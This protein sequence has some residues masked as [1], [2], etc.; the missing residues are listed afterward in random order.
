MKSLRLLL[1]M[2]L[3]FSASIV[4]A[5]TGECSGT[6][7]DAAEGTFDLGFDYTIV[8]NGEDVTVSVELLDIK[9]G[10]VAYAQTYNPDFAEVPMDN[11]GGQ[12]FSKTFPGQVD[13]NSFNVAIKFAF[14][15]GL[16]T[17]TIIE[18]TV[19]VG[20]VVVNT[21]ECSGTWTDA[22]EGTFD[23]GFDYSIITEGED[24]TVSVELL[25]IKDG[26]VAFA[27]TYTPDFAEVPMDNTGGQAFSKTFPGQVDGNSF[28]VAIKFAFAGGLTTSTIIEYTVGEGC[29]GGNTSDISL[30][31]TFEDEAIDYELNDFEGTTSQ[32]IIDPTDADNMV[33]ETVKSETA[34]FFAGTTVADVL[35]FSEPIP[36][37]AGATSMSVR[38]WSPTADTPVRL[39]VEQVG[40]PTVSVETEAMTT[41][42]EQWETL[43][44]NFTNQVDG[45]AAIN[46]ASIYNKATIFFNFGTTGADAG[47]QTYYWDDV[48]FVAPDPNI[49]EL[50]VTFEDS[51]A[52]YELNDF[53]GTTSQI[54]T[55]P[56][57]G[58][59]MVVET[60]KSET[61]AFFAG[62]TVADLSGFS[63]PIPF[64]AGSTSMTVRVWSP[65]ADT[66]VRLKV[67][68]VGVPTVSVE[69]EAMTTV[70]EEWETLTF[71]FSNQVDGT[72]AINLAS[73]YN[74]ATI[75]F[76][77]G[78]TGAD[79]GAQT[80]YWDDVAFG[81]A[82]EPFTVV[83]VIVNS[84]DHNTLEA[85][86]IAAELI[87]ALN[88]DG[89]F[90]VFAPTDEAFANLP[91][92]I[93]DALLSDPTGDLQEVLLY[94]VLG[95]EVLAADITAGDVTTLQGEDVSISIVGEDVFVNDA[96]VTIT[97]LVADNG[98]VHVI[99]A[100]LVPASIVI[101]GLD[102][103]SSNE[104]IKVW[105]NP[106]VD[107]LNISFLDGNIAGTTLRIFDVAGRLIESVNV[108][109]SM[110]NVQT[111]SF[112]AGNYIMR[113]DT[114]EGGFYHK[115]MVTK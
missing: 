95:M 74:K 113:I 65:T 85:A 99:D 53:E 44:F 82:P 47:A 84:D 52:N 83:D 33:V 101:I 77:F 10:L 11:T 80:Y 45:T 20:C 72:A 68:Q 32:I 89:P 61:A 16:A 103:I 73:I 14:A 51:E 39:K 56:T 88:G 48:A 102:E 34:A 27:Q 59:N 35:G 106:A 8:T 114:P 19:G 105:P 5:Q 91:A 18:Y 64:M 21:T 2:L 24:V 63:E 81:S 6:W 12:A 94:H 38:V 15:G 58:G 28:N 36:F 46:L 3:G 25:D 49:I 93:L 104:N 96:L 37:E 109:S 108:Q 23:L 54:I 98:V 107:N 75:F 4:N 92:G 57:D 71:D 78:T 110:V 42:S 40:V 7:T 87:D 9:D 55:D 30:P 79:A 22:A 31:V 26:L 50:P 1:V 29:T 67:E 60:V 100:V 86:L 17:S 90:T 111:S 115:F 62:T 66:P 76:N 13:G 43:T 69:T 97:D 70:A 41:V 112:Q